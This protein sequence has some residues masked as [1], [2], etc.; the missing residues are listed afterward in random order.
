MLINFTRIIQTRLTQQRSLNSTHAYLPKTVAGE[1][2]GGNIKLVVYNSL[3][4]EVETIIDKVLQPAVYEVTW[5]GSRFASG[6]YIYRFLV[7]NPNG[8]DVVY[9]VVKKMVMLK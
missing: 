8:L 6:V 9:D 2:R 7:T 3:G 1:I 5:D 4:Q